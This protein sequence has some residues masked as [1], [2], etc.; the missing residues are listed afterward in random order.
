MWLAKRR[1]GISLPV[2][3][4]RP[5]AIVSLLA[6]APDLGADVTRQFSGRK[7]ESTAES[8]EESSES[9]SS[10]VREEQVEEEKSHVY[11]YFASEVTNINIVFVLALMYC[12]VAPFMMLACDSPATQHSP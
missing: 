10:E 11:C 9:E 5:D 3:L 8:S 4:L 2:L 6:G 1:I 12:V 7:S